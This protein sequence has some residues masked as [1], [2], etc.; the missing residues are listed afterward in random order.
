MDSTFHDENK[1]LRRRV[2][3]FSAGFEF[4]RVLGECGAHPWPGMNHRG[5]IF[6]ARQSCAYKC[7]GRQQKMIGLLGASRMAEIMHG[8]SLM[9]KI[10][11]QLTKQLD[12]EDRKST[13]LNS[14]H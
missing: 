13:R 6:H 2:A 3:E 8:A 9:E 4:G 7:V 11:N 1:T 14:S 5:A 12:L 10:G